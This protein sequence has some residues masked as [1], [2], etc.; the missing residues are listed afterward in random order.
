ML[1]RKITIAATLMAAAWAVAPAGAQP[2]GL[3]AAAVK[4]DITPTT[5]KYLVG[6][7]ERKNTGV[8]DHIFTRVVALD[9]GSTQFFLAS[10]DICLFA[11]S[12]YDEFA[13]ELKKETGI[14][15]LQVWW[16]TTH[17][18]SAPEVGPPGIPKVIMPERYNH[19]VDAEYTAF[20]E[21]SLIAAVKEARTKL[22]PARLVVGTG[23]SAANI[24]RRATDIQGR[25]SLG[26]NPDGPVDRQINLLR[27][28]RPDGTPIALVS[29]YPVHGTSLGGENLLISGDVP[30]LVSQYVEEKIGAPMLFINGAAGNL[31]PIYETRRNFSD[32]HI[33][34]FNQLLGD[35]ILAANSVMKAPVSNIHFQPGEKIVE[36]ARRHGFGWDDSVGDYLKAAPGEDGV[37]RMPVRFLIVNNDLA[38]WTAPVEMFCEISMDIRSRSPYLHTFYFGYL[39]GWF[40]YL[41][42]KQAFAE[43]GYETRTNPFTDSVE[44]D[45]KNVVIPELQSRGH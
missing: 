20:V 27:L 15:R 21:S 16:A 9:D 8:H 40:G 44:A 39:N 24:N 23:Y 1:S 17:T 12:I 34:Q 2:A 11:P 18:H 3:R 43:G 42:T 33:T 6:Y 38:I 37:I 31:A 41:P 19:A 30:G 10:S 29:N 26:L 13:A 45:L 5:S 22:E 7:G 32:A 14:D 36:T 35:K 4:V 28:E 25:S